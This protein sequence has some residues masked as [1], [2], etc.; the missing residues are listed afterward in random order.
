MSLVL[1]RDDAMLPWRCRRSLLRLLEALAYLLDTAADDRI[2]D[3]PPAKANER[4]V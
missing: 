3:D 4:D 1:S 2:L